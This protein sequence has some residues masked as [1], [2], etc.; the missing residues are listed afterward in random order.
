MSS[1]ATETE[2][3]RSVNLMQCKSVQCTKGLIRR[4]R[5]SMPC[6]G[7]SVSKNKHKIRPR[8]KEYLALHHAKWYRKNKER[9]IQYSKEW[10]AKNPERC[11]ER[12]R[13]WARANTPLMNAS[14]K[15]RHAMKRHAMPTWADQAAMKAIYQDAARLTKETGIK[16]VVDHIIPLANS[17]VCGLHVADNL[18]VL[19]AA[20]NLRKWNHFATAFSSFS[21]SSSSSSF[22]SG[23]GSGVGAGCG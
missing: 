9:Q 4:P 6:G 22:G 12:N 14:K 8:S 16:H 13:R 17:L 18:Q 1:V 5:E 15:K 7:P 10:R 3:A 2:N 11:R 21:S 23:G 19:T 20:A